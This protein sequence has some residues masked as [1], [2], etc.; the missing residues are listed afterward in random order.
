[1]PPRRFTLAHSCA[2]I[3]AI[4]WSDFVLKYR[5]SVLGYVWSLLGPLV[6]FLVI[7]HIFGPY[8]QQSIANYSFY[9]FLGVI[10]WE[11]FAV[12]TT[13]CMSMLNEKASIIQ[14]MVFPRVFLILAVGWTNL[15]IFL[16]HLLIFFVGMLYFDVSIS[17]SA[18]YMLVTILQMSLVALGIGMILSS[19][20]LKYRDVAHMWSI[21]IQILFWLTPIM[22]PYALQGGSLMHAVRALTGQEGASSILWLFIKIQP[23][24]IIVHDARRAVLYDATS[25]SPTVEHAIGMTIVCIA[26]FLIGLLIFQRRQRY[27]P[28]EY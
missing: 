25:D 22:Y 4:G 19:Y 27:F 1:M 17:V 12:T 2:V 10:I 7:L 13:S 15:I 28:Q 6:R 24:S 11:H 3:S 8:V 21:A 16:T 9:L 18:M 23:L 26:I 5:G 20:S 14:R